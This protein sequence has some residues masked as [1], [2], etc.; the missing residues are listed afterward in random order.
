M[1]YQFGHVD[2][3]ERIDYVEG[4][5]Y[6]DELPPRRNLFGP[7]TVNENLQLGLRLSPASRRA[8]S[9][10]T[11][12]LR[13]FGAGVPFASTITRSLL[14]TSSWRQA[15]TPISGSES[16]IIWSS[17]VNL[18]ASSCTARIPNTTS[19]LSSG[20]DPSCIILHTSSTASMKS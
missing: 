3:D 9:E 11:R 14:P 5:Q 4:P 17:E 10:L 1:S 7:L 19:F 12:S 2:R 13:V 15:S 18:S 8:S 20:R 6:Q 16:W